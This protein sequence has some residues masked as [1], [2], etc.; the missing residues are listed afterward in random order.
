MQ[1]RYNSLLARAKKIPNDRAHSYGVIR[2]AVQQVIL[3]VA[4]QD[5]IVREE[6]ALA[7]IEYLRIPPDDETDE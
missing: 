4:N 3:S 2:N 7:P 6:M 5:A 1:D